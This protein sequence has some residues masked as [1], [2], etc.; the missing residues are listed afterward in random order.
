[1]IFM[2]TSEAK[3]RSFLHFSSR[4]VGHWLF[5]KRDIC[6]AVGPQPG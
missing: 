2:K 4:K 3:F 5:R 1:M 6:V